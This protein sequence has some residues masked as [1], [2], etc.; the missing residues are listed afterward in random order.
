[1]PGEAMIRKLLLGFALVALALVALPPLWF[2]LMREPSSPELPP[3][4]RRVSLGAELGV[5]VNV[6]DGGSGAPV[7]LSHGLPGS[8]YDWREVSAALAARGVRAIAYDRVGYGRSDPRPAAS[9]QTPGQNAR[10]LRAL[11]AALDL[12]DAT[13]AGWSYGGVVAML[14]ALQGDPRIGRIALVGTGGPDSPDAAPPEPPFLMRVLYSDPVLAWRSRVPPVGRVL[15]RAVSEQAFSGGAQPGWWLPGL[16]ANFARAE[17]LLAYRGE[18]FGIGARPEDAAAFEPAKLA[19][20]VLILHGDDDRLAPVGI[21]RY[22]AQVI[23]GA[24]L[25][26]VEGGSHMLPVTH[27]EFVADALAGFARGEPGAGTRA[28]ERR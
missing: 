6:L 18:M 11:L 7:V 25:R 16:R 14:A 28:P 4:G 26:L 13:I 27:A 9:P 8:G 15:M 20:P 1:M 17:T 12:R 2:A 22:L 24:E 3:A 10:E 21:A 19:L 5:H 23:P